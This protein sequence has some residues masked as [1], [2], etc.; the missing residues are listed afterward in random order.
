MGGAVTFGHCFTTC[1]SYMMVYLFGY[2]LCCAPCNFAICC[3]ND[4]PAAIYLGRAIIIILLTIPFF[5]FGLIA[6]VIGGV[7]GLIMDIIIIIM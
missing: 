7:I 6:V 2:A 1:F 4:N 3:C 5:I